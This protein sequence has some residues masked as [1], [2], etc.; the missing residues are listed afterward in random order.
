MNKVDRL[1]MLRNAGKGTNNYTLWSNGRP[2]TAVKHQ[3]PF[4]S[5][6]DTILIIGW[7]IILGLV[8]ALAALRFLVK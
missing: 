8:F 6:R 3:V 7:C 5:T 1:Q 2:R 4:V